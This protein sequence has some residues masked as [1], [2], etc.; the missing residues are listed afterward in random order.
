MIS[1]VSMIVTL[2][3]IGE[4]KAALMTV[5]KAML[6][7][8]CISCL[9]RLFIVVRMLKLYCFSQQV[10]IIVSGCLLSL[11]VKIIGIK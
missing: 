2:L 10:L 9:L 7:I 6:I 3:Y 1:L 8:V 11:Q 4:L 5:N